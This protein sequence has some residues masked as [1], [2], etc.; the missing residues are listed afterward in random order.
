MVGSLGGELIALVK[1]PR[2][3]A[4]PCPGPRTEPVLPGLS[5]SWAGREKP[6]EQALDSSLQVPR[7][8]RAEPGRTPAG[9]Q[10][11]GAEPV[12]ELL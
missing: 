12:G 6:Q 11:G 2:V 1:T 4:G 8:R 3:W 5:A 9:G 7:Q 10:V